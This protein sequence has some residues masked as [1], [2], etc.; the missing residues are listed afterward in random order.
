MVNEP[1]PYISVKFIRL[2]L[3]GRDVKIGRLRKEEEN[4][5]N[6][7]NDESKDKLI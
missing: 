1:F 6:F 7:R 2:P 5:V 4:K 3:Y